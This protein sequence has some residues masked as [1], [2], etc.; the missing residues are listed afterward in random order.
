MAT[1]QVTLITKSN[2]VYNTIYCTNPL[3]LLIILIIE[4]L[5]VIILNI[6]SKKIYIWIDNKIL[7]K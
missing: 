2:T 7:L 1:S 6:Y 5:M 3:V 4:N